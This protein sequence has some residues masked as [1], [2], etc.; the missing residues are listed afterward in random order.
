MALT[1]DR[2]LTSSAGA[3]RLHLPAEVVLNFTVHSDSDPSSVSVSYMIS[4]ENAYLFEHPDGLR[5]TRCIDPEVRI[6]G[7]PTP[8]SRPLRVV[9]GSGGSTPPFF[10]VTVSVTELSSGSTVTTQTRLHV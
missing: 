8:I 6:G 2:R 7:E 10:R 3:G 1:L 5:S 4:E 9:R